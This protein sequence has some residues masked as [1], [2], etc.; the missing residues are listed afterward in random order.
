MIG[1]SSLIVCRQGSFPDNCLLASSVLGREL[2]ELLV[3]IVIARSVGW[4]R[5]VERAV[6]GRVLAGLRVLAVLRW[7]R[8][9]VL[10]IAVLR[11]RVLSV[12]V[13]GTRWVLRIVVLI[14]CG[15]VRHVAGVSV[16]G[17][18]CGWHHLSLS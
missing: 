7:L 10:R 18:R 5:L 13:L 9:W 15:L 14:N 3:A 6:G 1:R 4:R 8:R 2:A 12:G 16:A 11:V 17:H